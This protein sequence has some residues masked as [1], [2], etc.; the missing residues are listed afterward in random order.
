MLKAQT[1]KKITYVKSNQRG[2]EKISKSFLIHTETN[3]WVKSDTGE[4]GNKELQDEIYIA[5]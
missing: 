4:Q 5:L 3:S 1:R 2:R